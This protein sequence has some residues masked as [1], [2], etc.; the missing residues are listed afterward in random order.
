MSTKLIF[1]LAIFAVAQL[2]TAVYITDDVYVSEL[3]SLR[4][5][6]RM[7]NW[8]FQ[9]LTEQFQYRPSLEGYPDLPS[10]VR[11]MYSTEYHS[12][13]LYG[14]PPE[15]TADSK[16]AIEIIALNKQTYETKRIVLILSV[17]RKL[18]PRNVIQMKIDNLNWVHMMDPGRIENLK[19]IFRNDLWQESRQDLHII[20][21]DSAIKLGARLPLKPQ[22]REGVVVHLGSRADFSS[23]LL[24]LQEEVKPLYKIAS[25]TYKRTS[26]QTTFENSGF[27]LDWCAFKMQAADDDITA[28]PHHPNESYKPAKGSEL[29]NLHRSDKWEA[30]MKS[31]VPERNYSDEFA[32]SFAI[33]GMIFVLLLSILTVILC[34]QHE[35][36][37]DDDSEYYFDFLFNICTDFFRHEYRPVQAVQMVQYSQQSTIQ[38]TGTLKSL[39][40]PSY[41]E[42]LSL[43]SASPTESHYPEG[44]PRVRNTYLRPKPPP[45]KPASGS[46]SSTMQRNVSRGVDM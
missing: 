46:N 12:G 26:V 34:F 2:S 37:R 40:E 6:P 4:V 3:F 23:R 31:E 38:P 27:K 42:N 21:M 43:R 25:C 32:V 19:N 11:Y 8:T 7:F 22:Q 16:V 18:P 10:W 35:K 24:D 36:L 9:G 39:K 15:R 20:F 30:P 28:M 5:E 29:S 1:L 14:T 13:F 41:V 33:P 44:S 17:H 45:Y